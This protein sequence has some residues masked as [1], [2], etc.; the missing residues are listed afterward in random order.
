MDTTKK[1]IAVDARVRIIATVKG[2][3]LTRAENF[4]TVIEIDRWLINNAAAQNAT[5]DTL[6]RQ[7]FVNTFRER[8][9]KDSLL[10]RSIGGTRWSVDLIHYN[11]RD[12]I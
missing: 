9:R 1:K 3:E 10:R 12:A 8:M 4:S 7:A 6:T 11:Y 5:V 2:H